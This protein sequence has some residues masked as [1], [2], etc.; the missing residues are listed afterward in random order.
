MA[1]RNRHLSI[2][3]HP[4]FFNKETENI[5]LFPAILASLGLAVLWLYIPA[6]QRVLGTATVPVAH[7]FYPAALGIGLLSLDE[8]RKACV[9]RWPKSWIAAMAW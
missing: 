2:V 6:L 7:Y 3:Q 9:R 8:I 4:P 5:P 1:V